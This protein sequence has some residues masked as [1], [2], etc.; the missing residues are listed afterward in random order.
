MGVCVLRVGLGA[1]GGFLPVVWG[2]IGV[3]DGRKVLTLG[4]DS[5]EWLLVRRARCRAWVTGLSTGAWVD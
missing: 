3:N 2:I 4:K 1:Y 5:R